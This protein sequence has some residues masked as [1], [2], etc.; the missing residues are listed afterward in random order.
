MQGEIIG[1]PP[2]YG[3]DS[4]RPDVLQAPLDPE[5][6]KAFG[7][8]VEY[9]RQYGDSIDAADYYTDWKSGLLGYTG[10]GIAVGSVLSVAAGTP[11]VAMG[12]LAAT[13][14]TV[15]YNN[16]R[17]RKQV[18]EEI[19][20]RTQE[21][22]GIA[23]GEQ[24]EL[25]SVTDKVTG[26]NEVVLR[27]QG[28]LERAAE[29][30]A[31][32]IPAK[33]VGDSIGLLSD[34]AERH[35]IRAVLVDEALLPETYHAE[36][37]AAA[38]VPVGRWISD[39]KSLPVNFTKN[40]Q[41]T[42]VDALAFTPAQLRRLSFNVLR[43]ERLSEE[44]EGVVNVLRQHE[45]G[46]PLVRKFDDYKQQPARLQQELQATGR[47]CLERKLEDIAGI[48]TRTPE[49][50]P[51]RSKVYMDG[52]IADGTVTWQ[53]TGDRFGQIFGRQNVL[54]ALNLSEETITQTIENHAYLPPHKVVTAAEAA[55]YLQASLPPLPVEMD[56]ENDE[57]ALATTY[58]LQHAIFASAHTF[59]ARH[60]VTRTIETEK[61][62]V[63]TR[64]AFKHRFALNLLVGGSVLAG[65]IQG[66]QWLQQQSTT[67]EQA[68]QKAE[69]AASYIE[70][71]IPT[72]N[73]R[74]NGS[75]G[76][77]VGGSRTGLGHGVSSIGNSP[78]SK[79]DAA[80]EWH[81]E[82][83]G[84]IST[85]GYWSTGTM[86]VM[87]FDYR[88]YRTEDGNT[89]LDLPEQ[90]EQ[91][92]DATI[93]V[94]RDTDFSDW[95][96]LGD[97]FFTL[98]VPVLQGT[99]PVA[100]NIDGR[101]TGVLLHDDN[102]FSIVVNR[103]R[104]LE[105]AGSDQRIN[106]W[107]AA[108]SY[109]GVRATS[110]TS[111]PGDESNYNHTDITDT[112]NEA[113]GSAP[114]DPEERIQAEVDYIHEHFTYS[115]EP[116]S[117]DTMEDMDMSG[118]ML[119]FN[120]FLQIALDE[121]KANCNVAAALVAMDNPQLNPAVGY[122]NGTDADSKPESLQSGESHMWL[123]DSE[124]HTIDPTP[125]KE[126]LTDKIENILGSKQAAVLAGFALVGV[127]FEVVRRR[128]RRWRAQ[129]LV[130]SYS[131]GELYAAKQVADRAS[132]AKDFD[133]RRIQPAPESLGREK[134]LET[135]SKQHLHDEHVSESLRTVS[136]E[137]PTRKQ[138]RA[139][140]KA[141]RVLKTLRTAGVV[142]KLAH[143]RSGGDLRGILS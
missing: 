117:D 3:S 129:K 79:G 95:T 13:S 126:A 133:L 115:L 99:M 71:L 58:Y 57:P 90:P 114:V 28:S 38:R 24:Y 78:E 16:H 20:E 18:S 45:P 12:A 37:Y 47:R 33:P 135:A 15:A 8:H 26:V 4:A 120:E 84:D 89:F 63:K 112:W 92:Y 127:A 122:F 21:E 77:Y 123:V 62:E 17:R 54:N 25:H 143:Q 107:L 142:E 11:L 80:T 39:T 65:F 97:D 70:S 124:G 69:D 30:G 104:F 116:L 2:Q 50:V 105:L 96:Q 93:K 94:S 32:H 76:N 44:L 136:R 87:D 42:D 81:L 64:H 22:I 74:D 52:R 82:T 111:Y 41:P 134:A 23:L 29:E 60:P 85:E 121:E 31:P 66:D 55:V 132:F 88:T 35:N 128:S 27:W 73:A 68:H 48:R 1:L 86:N 91:E 72:G 5:V 46:H 113:L 100:S 118:P 34:L 61:L 140:R 59:D 51:S 19:D 75:Y 9:V 108:G 14:G 6:D 56:S 138:R 7:E 139:A 137:A 131:T 110:G 125:T 130:D 98:D 43:D 83:T 101:Y 141:Q 49:G 102:S 119:P 40:R 36:R 109:M 106:Y 53:G 67:Y 10:R 103:D